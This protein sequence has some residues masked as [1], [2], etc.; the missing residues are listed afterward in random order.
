MTKIVDM[1]AAKQAAEQRKYAD[2]V[3]ANYDDLNHQHQ[4][5]QKDKA[6]EVNR[7]ARNKI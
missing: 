6:A 7:Q 2:L 1:K 3:L 5:D 4:R